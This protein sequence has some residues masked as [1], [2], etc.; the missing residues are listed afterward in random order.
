MYPHDVD[1]LRSLLKERDEEVAFL[2]NELSEVNFRLER[3]VE[4]SQLF[5][6]FLRHGV[7]FYDVWF[8]FPQSPPRRTS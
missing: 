1:E 2:K 8:C 3:L 7:P 6:R 5:G 4:Q